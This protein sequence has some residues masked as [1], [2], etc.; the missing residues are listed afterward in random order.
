MAEHGRVQLVKSVDLDEVS[1]KDGRLQPSEYVPEG[2]QR[3]RAARSGRYLTSEARSGPPGRSNFTASTRRLRWP[4][5]LARLAGTWRR[6]HDLCRLL[7]LSCSREPH[8]M[9]LMAS[10]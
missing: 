8:V 6:V 1:G 2:V 5:T 10:D 9:R 7:A 3:D 4:S